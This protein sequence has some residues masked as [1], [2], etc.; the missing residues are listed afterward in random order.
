MKMDPVG[1]DGHSVCRMIVRRMRDKIRWNACHDKQRSYA[2]R[3]PRR[4]MP[5]LDESD[6]GAPPA[7]VP[8][9]WKVPCD[10]AFLIQYVVVLK[11]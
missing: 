6:N 11:P 3:N 7:A 1:S 10:G 9:F 4:R 2:G 5:P 8:C